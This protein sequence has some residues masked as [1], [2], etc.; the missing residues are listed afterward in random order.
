MDI[1]SLSSLYAAHINTLQKRSREVMEREGLQALVIHSGQLKRQFLD[2]IEYP[3]KVNPHFKHWLPLTE[4]ANCWLV[5]NGSDKPKLIYYQP[6]D[7]WHKVSDLGEPFFAD[8]FDIHIL[9]KASDVGRIL[10]RCLDGHAY[11]GE[12]IEVAQAL[13][14]SAIN[15]EPV[16]NYLHYYRAYKTEYEY[17]C[18]RLASQYAASAHLAAKRSFEQGGTEYEI[19]QS[20]L[21]ACQQHE[22][23]MPYGNIVALNENAAILHYTHRSQLK[24][25]QHKSFLIDAGFQF[26]GYAC[27]ISRTYSANNDEFASLILAL[28]KVQ[29]DLV[30]KLKPGRPYLDYHVLC[31]R[32]IAELLCQYQF[33]HLDDVE[34]VL[35]LGIVAYFFPHGLGHHLGLQVH[36]VGG[37]MSDARGTH[38]NSPEQYPFLRNMREVEVGNVLTIEPG[39]YFIDS[40]L[41]QLKQ[42]ELQSYINW[43]KVEEFKAYGGIRIEDNVIVHQTRNENVTRDCH[44]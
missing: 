7:F 14:F 1:E 19:N 26:Y 21:L 27:D 10:P 20:Y 13:G 15:P 31:H 17:Q 6:T 12:H 25:K 5:I 38:V 23:Q 22:Q 39:I 18:I 44:L 2:D 42:S 11:V 32:Y 41:A 35:K 34:Q 8:Y 9:Q 43:P 24:P 30:G 29:Q 28:D 33:I 37:F 40:L 36:D 4:L 3:F 16:L